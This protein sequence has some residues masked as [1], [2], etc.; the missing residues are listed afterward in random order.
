[1][2]DRFK[3]RVWN[4][5]KMNE[6]S[7][8]DFDTEKAITYK[9]TEYYDSEGLCIDESNEA[10]LM[11]CTGLKDKNGVLIYEADILKF[12]TKF[13]H[14]IQAGEKQEFIGKVY[15]AIGNS[16]FTIEN[17]DGGNSANFNQYHG[18]QEIEIIGN[19]YE[20]PELLK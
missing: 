17:E 4:E 20:N 18:G 1:M 11:Q 7:V 8:L 12:K 9:Y 15:F 14:D 19:I 3:F 6:V 16:A 13:L 10:C 5:G 2:Q